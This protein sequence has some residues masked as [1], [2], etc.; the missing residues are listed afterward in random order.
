MDAQ[1]VR[2]HPASPDTAATPLRRE[3]LWLGAIVAAALVIRV[4][5][6][7]LKGVHVER[8]TYAY[9]HAAKT[10]LSGDA[11]TWLYGAAKPPLFTGVLAGVMSLGVY[12][13]TAARII[14]VLA[15]VLMLHPAWLIFR[16]IGP[17]PAALLALAV[18]TVAR[19]PVVTAGQI[20]SNTLN[21][22]LVLYMTYFLVV[23]GLVDRR[24]WAF[25]V[26]GLFAGLAFLTR[27]EA[28]AYLPL[29][30][31]AAAWG[32]AWGRLTWRQAAGALGFVAAALLL[33]GPQVAL[34]S[35]QAGRFTI[36]QNAGQFLAFSAG[37][38][39]VLHAPQGHDVG[40][41]RALAD[42]AGQVAAAYAGH[43]AE[44]LCRIAPF[45][46]GHAGAPFVLVA[47]V[48]AGRRLL[49][50]GIWPLWLA[51]FLWLVLALSLFNP[52]AYMLLPVMGALVW[53]AGDGIRRSADL[54]I[55]WNPLRLRRPNRAR[56]WLLAGMILAVF[57]PTVY[58]CL[59]KDRYANHDVVAAA[60]LI[61][62]H[63]SGR[64][65][66]AVAGSYGQPA[67]R[68]DGRH[69][70]LPNR[71]Q[72][73]RRELADY[74]RRQGADYVILGIEAMKRM[75]LDFDPNHPPPFL[76]LLGRTRSHPKAR[77]PRLLCVYQVLPDAAPPAAADP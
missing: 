49:R 17:R 30:V 8:D 62:R 33:I 7:L 1:T 56:P 50:W 12:G 47:L 65:G 3:A 34:M 73:T 51:M 40:L 29:A 27:T 75:H 24:G 37:A 46:L 28:I 4:V 22:C 70:P 31:A 14:S 77:P 25:A 11:A 6:A 44:Y 39:D 71:W 36:R 72:M 26:G 69:V 52:H 10:L 9:V 45:T 76:K 35:A 38:T 18:L 59:R 54:I 5:A 41:L 64:R 19:Q 13:P 15:G 66:L 60:D 43:F 67:L 74:L 53:G 57:A 20:T 68:L 63:A 58:A 42:N 23:R 48:A 32:A 55:R 2:S 21:A 16:R 61:R